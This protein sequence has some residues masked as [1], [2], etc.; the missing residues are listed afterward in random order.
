MLLKLAVRDGRRVQPS[1]RGGM[2]ERR[3]SPRRDV[4]GELAFVPTTLN[5]RVYDI[6]TGGVMLGAAGRIEPGLLGRLRLNLGGTPFTADVQ[7]LR[8]ADAPDADGRYLAGTRFLNLDPA[9]QQ[10]I[11]RFMT[12]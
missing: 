3:R 6:S 7:I 10:L 1:G 2:E 11:E 12:Q 5:V 4:A 8:V 9:H